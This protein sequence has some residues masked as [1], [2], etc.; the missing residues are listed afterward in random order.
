MASSAQHDLETAVVH[1]S[2]QPSHSASERGVDVAAS[3]AVVPPPVAFTL[4][5]DKFLVMFAELKRARQAMASV[6]E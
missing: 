4:S 1:L 6:G 5:H 3:A 2:L